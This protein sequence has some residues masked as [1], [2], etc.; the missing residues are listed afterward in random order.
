MNEDEV[1]AKLN[2][3][4]SDY[5]N[6]FPNDSMTLMDHI[7][8]AIDSCVYD[9]K[10]YENYYCDNELFNALLAISE[11]VDAPKETK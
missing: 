9:L 6:E 5:F 4:I 2:E 11:L 10:G 8:D 3:E 7:E 1:N